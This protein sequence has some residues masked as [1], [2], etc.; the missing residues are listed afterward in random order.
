MLESLLGPDCYGRKILLDLQNT[1]YID[2]SGVSWL[3]NFHKHC[4]EA[5]G[6][7]VVHSVPSSIM[8]I[9]KLLH[10]D[11][12]LNLVEDEQAAQDHGPGRQVMKTTGSL[13]HSGRKPAGGA[14]QATEKPATNTGT[15]PTDPH[16]GAPNVAGLL[17]ESAVAALIDHAVR[18][19][20]SD[21]FFSINDNHV[22]VSVRHLGIVRL[23]TMLTPE[24]G[25]RCTSYI[26]VMAGMDLAEQRRP[27]D[28]RWVRG[29]DGIG[30]GRVDLRISTIPTLYGEDLSIRL[31]S[32]NSQR[33][34]LDQLGMMRKELN[35]LTGMLDIPSGLILVTGPTGS[36]KTTTL[37]GCLRYLNNGERKINTIEDPI[38]YAIPGLR[39]S[40]INPKAGGRL[41]RAAAERAPPVAGRDHDR[42]DPGPDHGRDGRPR[43]QQR[44]P[45]AGLAPRAVGGG[46]MQSMLSLG[47]HPHFLSNSLQ[48]VIAQRLVRTLCPECKVPFDLGEMPQ[49]F[50]E[51]RPWLEPGE[52]QYLYGARGCPKCFQTGYAGR[53]GVFEVLRMTRELRRLIA[54]GRPAREIRQKAVEEGLLDLRRAALLKVARGETNAEEVLRTIPSEELGLD[55]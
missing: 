9:L 8:A 50:E 35:E 40:Q 55:D 31:L 39:Q 47:A 19:P 18:M 21:L 11:R 24:Q 14:A 51:V 22:G 33:M 45:R 37:Y 38:E 28:G 36:G 26:K 13:S 44:P 34:V 16:S 5:G 29:E 12:Y 4:H 20:A 52:G 41:P 48:G 43:R 15:A 27:L 3:V 46:A 17:P 7:L 6:I 30:A 2:S 32:C 23:L 1:P 10:I 53:T 25:R 54:D 42:R 49:T